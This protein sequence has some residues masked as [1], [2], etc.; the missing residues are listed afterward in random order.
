VTT[1]LEDPD[2]AGSAEYREI[3]ELVSSAEDLDEAIAI[4]DEFKEW[5]KNTGHKLKAARA[6]A[7]RAANGF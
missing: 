2:S 3:Y 5:A 7:G 1:I 6:A 4:A